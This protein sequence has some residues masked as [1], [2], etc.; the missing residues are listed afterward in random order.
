MTSPPTM[1]AGM[2]MIAILSAEPSEKLMGVPSAPQQVTSSAVGRR[3]RKDLVFR[4]FTVPVHSASGRSLLTC[5]VPGVSVVHGCEWG[6]H[7]DGRV[8]NDG[9][10][11]HALGRGRAGTGFQESERGTLCQDA[12]PL[13]RGSG[14]RS[15][16]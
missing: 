2:A 15:S 3:V 16:T 14:R 10:R 4:G 9:E 1:S 5:N 11:R 13:V 7:G 8:A 12:E 6:H